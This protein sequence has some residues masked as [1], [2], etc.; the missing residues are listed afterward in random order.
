MHF[1]AN[2]P[3]AHKKNYRSNKKRYRCVEQFIFFDLLVFPIS[4]T[5]EMF[6]NKFNVLKSQPKI[7]F[8][9]VWW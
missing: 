1:L 2:V 4:K 7:P 5:T 6:I 8:R 3:C 9:N